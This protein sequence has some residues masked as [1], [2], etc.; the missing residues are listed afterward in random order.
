MEHIAVTSSN[1]RSVGYDA[2]AKVLVV[3][4]I[5]TGGKPDRAYEYHGVGRIEYDA[6]MAAPSIGKHMAQIKHAYR[7]VPL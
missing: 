4:Y 5:G 7:C 6:L 3:T 1:V 2:E